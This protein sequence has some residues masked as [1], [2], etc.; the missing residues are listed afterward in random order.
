[1]WNSFGIEINWEFLALYC[2]ILSHFRVTINNTKLLV[3]TLFISKNISQ[4][5]VFKLFNSICR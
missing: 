1:M 4:Y 2:L 3:S 5:V